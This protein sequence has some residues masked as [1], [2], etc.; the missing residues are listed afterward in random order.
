MLRGVTSKYTRHTTEFKYLKIMF[1]PMGRTD[2]N[3]VE[4]LELGLDALAKA[5]LKP[6]Q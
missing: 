4:R 5:P 2:H 1:S 3:N 6:L